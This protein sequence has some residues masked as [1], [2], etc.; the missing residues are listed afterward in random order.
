MVYGQMKDTG[1]CFKL[2]V[3][4]QSCYNCMN[5]AHTISMLIEND[6]RH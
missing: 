6:H 1:K 5:I 2:F 4:L 3:F